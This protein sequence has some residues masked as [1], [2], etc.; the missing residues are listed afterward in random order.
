MKNPLSAVGENQSHPV[1]GRGRCERATLRMDGVDLEDALEGD[2]GPCDDGVA[3]AGS[4]ADR[5]EVVS[6]VDVPRMTVGDRWGSH[7]RVAVP[8]ANIA[9]D[10]SEVWIGSLENIEGT[11]KDNGDSATELRIAVQQQVKQDHIAEEELTPNVFDAD[12]AKKTGP[13]IRAAVQSLD[14]VDLERI[15]QWRACVMKSAPRILNGPCRM[16]LRIFGVRDPGRCHSTGCGTSNSWLE[17]S[18][19]S[20]SNVILPTTQSQERRTAEV[21]AKVVRWIKTALRN[22]EKGVWS[23]FAGDVIR[24]L[25]S[26][27]IA[28]Q[29]GPAVERFSALFQ[30]ALFTRAGSECIAFLCRLSPSQRLIAQ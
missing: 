19:S 11:P 5:V 22:Q 21:P 29:L 23:I 20:L 26:R 10:D 24:L 16:A 25:V 3:S 17:S 6:D 7:S 27:T 30:Y 18:L 1:F 12:K 9:D 4:R 2:L 28:K 15:F 8:V 13:I 14:Q